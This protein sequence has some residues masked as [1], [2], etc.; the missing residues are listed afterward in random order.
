MWPP[1][2][3]SLAQ[4]KQA[5]IDGERRRLEAARVPAGHPLTA[6]AEAA[7]SQT[8]PPLVTLAD[9]L[10][11]PHVHYPL[12][13]AH[14]MG[15]PPLVAASEASD[16]PAAAEESTTA[17]PAPGSSE[18]GF[19]AAAAGASAVEAE[20]AALAEPGAAGGLQQAPAALTAAEKESVE[21]DIKYEGFIRRQAK[22][23][24]SVAAKHAKRIPDTLDYH[25]I[26]TLSMEAREKLS[27]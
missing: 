5:R 2:L 20:A 16:A 9:L 11:R 27:K 22:Q 23:L 15:A 14:G 25:A 13:E 21:V 12:L 18:A 10:R 17:A 26:H 1:T 19:A 8:V 24:A 3:P 6:A 4:A 7:S